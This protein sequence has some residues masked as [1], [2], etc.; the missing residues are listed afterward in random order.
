MQLVDSFRREQQQMDAVLPFFSF[1]ISRTKGVHGSL[2]REI[3]INTKGK[4]VHGAF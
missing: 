3:K 4:H 1:K 2:K